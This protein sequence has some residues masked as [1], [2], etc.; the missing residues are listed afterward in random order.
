MRTLLELHYDAVHFERWK[1]NEG[2][3][4]L[5]RSDY[6]VFKTAVNAHRKK[7]CQRLV[8]PKAVKAILQTPR[9]EDDLQRLEELRCAILHEIEGQDYILIDAPEQLERIATAIESCPRDTFVDEVVGTWKTYTTPARQFFVSLTTLVK[10][11][12]IGNHC[13]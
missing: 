2:K 8:L 9:H 6:Y 1:S 4:P 10:C 7:L 13:V 12:N 11:S 5:R 3:A